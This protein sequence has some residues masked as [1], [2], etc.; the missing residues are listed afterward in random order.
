[1]TFVTANTD[2]QITRVFVIRHGQTPWNAQKILQGHK[3]VPLNDIGREQAIRLGQHL[4]EKDLQFDKVIS[5]D[6]DRCISTMEAAKLPI[7]IKTP[8][9]RERFMGD[10][11]GLPLKEA[12]ERYGPA[13][14]NRGEQAPQM[15]DRI[16]EAWENLVVGP[17]N[18]N[19][20][21]CTHGGVI[22]ALVRELDPD[23]VGKGQAPFN[24]SIT[25]IDVPLNINDKNSIRVVGFGS[26]AHLGSQQSVSKEDLELR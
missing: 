4:R 26:T 13:F 24:T 1:M 25:V 9:F 23:G 11:E 17:G 22:R 14:R 21:V 15:V 10:V 8:L 3:N 5:S 6:L 18:L 16:M 7:H 12:K 20:A 2:P 19:V